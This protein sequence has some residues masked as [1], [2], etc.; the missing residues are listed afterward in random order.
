LTSKLWNT[1]HEVQHIRN[2]LLNTLKDLQVDYLDLWL[3]H[4]PIQVE[5][6]GYDLTKADIAPKDNNG[7]PRF[8]KVSHAQTWAEME[9]AFD[10]GL[11][12]SIGVSNFT[13]RELVD[14][15]ATAR[16]RPVV[17]QIEVSPLHT[18][19]DLIEFCSWHGVH[20]TSYST[21]GS[22]FNKTPVLELPVIHELSKKLNKT[23]AQVVLRWAIELGTSSVPKSTNAQ[24]M[25]DNLDIFDF[26][27]SREDVNRISAENKNQGAF[28][29][30]FRKSTFGFN[31]WV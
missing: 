21:F 25:K 2:A 11:V 8:S 26:Q 5:F 28:G 16:I 29:T 18:N 22:S 24:R 19:L 23:P 31:P 7:H 3:I 14:L 9:K 10:E 12:K 30:E 20:V 4:W 6:T 17:N 15:L 1:H 13:S 27:L